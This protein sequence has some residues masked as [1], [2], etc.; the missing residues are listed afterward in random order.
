[1]DIKN[2][3]RKSLSN[4]KPYTYGEQPD[5]SEWIKLNTNENPYE[6][7]E[8][9]LREIKE[10]VCGNRLRLYPDPICKELRQIISEN[11]F[12]NA[13]SP[14]NILVAN[15]SDEILDILFK[16]FVDPGEKII[17]FNPS[18]G[19]YPALAELFGAEIETL[20]L[21]EDFEIP[22]SAK[23]VEGKLMFV[24]SPNNPTGKAV[25]NEIIASLCENF[26]GLVIVD[27]A[28]SDFNN[29]NA[30]PL[31]ESRKHKNLVILR[32]FSKAFSLASERIG[33]LIADEEIINMMVGTKLPYNVTYLSQMTAIS[34]MR[35]ISEYKKRIKLII[36][37]RERIM[38][39]L[40]KISKLKPI[41]SESNFIL[42]KFESESIA[43]MIFNELKNNKIL[44][45]QYNK[46]SLPEYLRLTIGKPK[47]N[48]KVLEMI[49]KLI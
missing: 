40:L 16:T 36:D 44:I 22:N 26:N 47:D 14:K 39:E 7:L 2:L 24:C 49:R 27:E 30:I 15:G 17:N 3:I 42:I 37:E 10:A 13:I 19:M 33:L 29:F 11:L 35:H 5:T 48:D 8:I 45:R 46:K 12:N 18:Y 28:Y 21:T 20:S 43:S 9:V 1:M 25:K 41:T 6:P 23:L 34:T 38:G 31:L 4:Y 32:T